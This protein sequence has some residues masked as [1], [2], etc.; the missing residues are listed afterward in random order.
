M[1]DLILWNQGK[2]DFI[3][4]KCS[5][6]RPATCP[7]SKRVASEYGTG[8]FTLSNAICPYVTREKRDQTLARPL[9][10]IKADDYIWLLLVPPEHMVL[11]IFVKSELLR[12]PQSS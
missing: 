3:V 6:D 12:I 2:L 7:M 8:Y 5:N 4:P 10:E 1:A 11:D 9:Q